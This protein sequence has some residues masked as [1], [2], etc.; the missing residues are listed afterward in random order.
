MCWPD[1]GSRL[2]RSGAEQF[3]G[4]KKLQGGTAPIVGFEA[5]QGAFGKSE[6]LGIGDTQECANAFGQTWRMPNQEGMFSIRQGSK[7][8][9]ELFLR[10]IVEERVDFAKLFGAH[11]ATAMQDGFSRFTRP[12][13]GTAAG[14]V[15]R[16]TDLLQ[17]PADAARLAP[18]ARREW[19]GG[20][21]G[22]IQGISMPQEIESHQQTG[23]ADSG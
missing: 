14:K 19:S 22:S 4:E 16:D 8:A 12:Y 7:P 13:Q 3:W 20:I 6:S 5:G 2:D 10:A 21:V 9:I 11:G 18:A 1:G 17:K 15:K 23:K